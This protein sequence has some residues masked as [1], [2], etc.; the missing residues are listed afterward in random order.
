[1]ADSL[2][3]YIEKEIGVKF[4]IDWMIDDFQVHL[5]R[6]LNLKIEIY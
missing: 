4:S 3:L 5:N 2:I 6:W 1:M